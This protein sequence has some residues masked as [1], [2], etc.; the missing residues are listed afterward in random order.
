MTTGDRNKGWSKAPNSMETVTSPVPPSL[1][2]SQWGLLFISVMG[3]SQDKW[4]SNTQKNSCIQIGHQF[5]FFSGQWRQIGTHSSNVC[6]FTSK[7]LWV[8][9]QLWVNASSEQTMATVKSQVIKG[10]ERP[11]HQQYGA[12]YRQFSLAGTN[13]RT[14]MAAVCKFVVFNLADL[15]EGFSL[16]LENLQPRRICFVWALIGEPAGIRMRTLYWPLMAL[17]LCLSTCFLC[18]RFSTCF[19]ADSSLSPHRCSGTF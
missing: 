8:N 7:Q 10:Q 13:T 6:L 19:W 14:R 5:K 3:T 16:F 1:I 11:K 4:Y 2:K 9:E 12:I 15:R 18:L 17:P